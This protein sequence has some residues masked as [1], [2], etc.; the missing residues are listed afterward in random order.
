MLDRVKSFEDLWVAFPHDRACRQLL[1]SII[2]RRG[3]FCPHCGGLNTWPSAA[4]RRA[5]ASTSAPTAITSSPSPPAP[6][7][8]PPSCR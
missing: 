6:R 2:W 7:C 1:E 4:R 3:R 5:M 8:M